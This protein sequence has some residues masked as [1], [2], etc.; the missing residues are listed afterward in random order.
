MHHVLKQRRS[1]DQDKRQRNNC[2]IFYLK[3]VPLSWNTILWLFIIAS[4]I[5][6]TDEDRQYSFNILK[7]SGIMQSHLDWWWALERKWITKLLK[8]ANDENADMF[9]YLHVASGCFAK[10]PEVIWQPSTKGFSSFCRLFYY[11]V[12]CVDRCHWKTTHKQRLSYNIT[13]VTILSILAFF[14]ATLLTMPHLSSLQWSSQFT[15]L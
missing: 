2:N 9:W 3:N 13:K 4:H 12:T 1:L 15:S 6:T 8:S 11:R 14:F 5:L 10:K 7:K